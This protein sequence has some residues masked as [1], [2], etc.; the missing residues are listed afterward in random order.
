MSPPEL[1]LILSP[2][3][4]QDL[5]DILQYTLETWGEAQLVAYRAVLEK[6]IQAIVD[7]PQIAPLRPDISPAHRTLLA[8][9]HVVVYRLTDSA[10]LVSRFLHARMDVRRHV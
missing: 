5:A 3:A 1:C 2:Q 7:N 6:A 10:I 9:S 8:G 4:E